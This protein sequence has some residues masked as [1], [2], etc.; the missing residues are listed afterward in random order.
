[1]K[2]FQGR[3]LEALEHIADD[4]RGNRDTTKTN[5]AIPDLS[6]FDGKARGMAEAL[7]EFVTIERHVE[8]AAWKAARL[9]PPERRVLVGRDAAGPVRGCRSGARGLPDVTR[10]IERR[11][12]LKEEQR[13]GY[14]ETH[15]E[16]K[17]VKLSKEEKALS[18]PLPI[19]DPF[20]LRID[21]G[22]TGI[23]LDDALA[24]STLSE[25]DRVVVEPRWTTD[26]GCPPRSRRR[27]RR[28]RSSSSTA[29]EWRSRGSR[30]S[31][32]DDGRA[33]ACWLHLKPTPAWGSKSPP[34]FT[35][36]GLETTFIDGERYTH[37]S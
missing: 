6:T 2:G 30:S 20:R 8:L 5:F 33:T 3:R 19:D 4:F 17:Q 1:M 23:T 14:L 34:G 35:F 18:D 21:V 15:P 25:G 9:A 11:A 28:P 31:V 10:R 7:Q 32:T 16:A 29:C 24:L 27:S 26:S 22:E 12:E 13:A 37:R 36:S